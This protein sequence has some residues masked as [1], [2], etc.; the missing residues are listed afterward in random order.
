MKKP[1]VKSNLPAKSASK[2][3]TNVDEFDN[4]DKTPKGLENVTAADLILPRITILQAL[5]PQLIK[6]RP[7]FIPSA[8]PGMFC[9]TAT[10]KV[11]EDELLF[12]PCFFA[13]I[14][15]EWAPRSSGQGLVRNHGTDASI[16]DETERDE[17]NRATLKNG[18][19]I[20]E[21]AT[22]YGLNGS[23]SWRRSFV[24]LT[25]TQLSASRRWMM[26]ITNEKLKRADGSEFTPPIYYRSWKASIVELTKNDNDWFGWAFEPA[27]TIVEIDPSKRLLHEAKDFYSQS[28]KGLVRGDVSQIQEDDF[29]SN[30]EG[31]M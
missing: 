30:S 1:N 10:G 6:K 3:I 13:R 26:K 17:T 28:Q 16:L 24:P 2:S 11:F 7:E 25:S 20:A 8:K 19:Y 29:S 5:S 4:G 9:D 12:I 27:G 31:R 14:F 15:L 18:N 22:Y 23:D 21:T